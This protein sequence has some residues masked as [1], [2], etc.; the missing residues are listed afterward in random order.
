[1]N[2]LFHLHADYCMRLL[3][4]AFAKQFRFELGNIT[5]VSELMLSLLIACYQIVPKK[6]IVD[7]P[8]IILNS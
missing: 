8:Y 6:Q 7:E 3:G 2:S 1:M 4:L 5:T